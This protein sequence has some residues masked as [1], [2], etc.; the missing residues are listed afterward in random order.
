MKNKKGKK[1]EHSNILFVP[2]LNKP[3]S[4]TPS[5]DLYDPVFGLF[6]SNKVYFG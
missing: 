5:A 6:G 4:N 1:N 2:V 3:E